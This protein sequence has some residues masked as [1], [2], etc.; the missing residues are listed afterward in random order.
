[1]SNEV[2]FFTLISLCLLLITSCIWLSADLHKANDK[3]KALNAE[4]VELRQKYYN[5]SILVS[6]YQE[7]LDRYREIDPLS[8]SDFSKLVEQINNE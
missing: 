1:M 3:V 2:R 4:I 8:A 5:D 6:E 7:A